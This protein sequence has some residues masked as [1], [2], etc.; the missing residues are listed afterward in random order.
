MWTNVGEFGKMCE[1][2]ENYEETWESVKK[3]WDSAIFGTWF[4]EKIQVSEHFTHFV[5]LWH[6]FSAY[7]HFSNSFTHFITS[8]DLHCPTL[9]HIL[10]A[11]FCTFFHL[12][13]HFFDNSGSSELYTEFG[14]D[15]STVLDCEDI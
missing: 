10:A 9:T 4:F 15:F 2:V 11:L 8:Y 7:G 3:M 1:N 6:I 5:T 12:Y 14:H 13:V